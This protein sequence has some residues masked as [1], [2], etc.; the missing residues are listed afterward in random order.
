[1][2]LPPDAFAASEGYKLGEVPAV[3]VVRG[4]VDEV[5]L[6]ALVTSLLAIRGETDDATA[7]PTAWSDYGRR[8][9]RKGS[10]PAP[11]A[12]TWRWSAHP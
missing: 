2:T 10:L 11:G 9:A 7:T 12:T 5:E 4:E 3:T 8:L 6:A 1:M